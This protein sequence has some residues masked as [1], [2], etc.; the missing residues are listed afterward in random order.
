MA[1]KNKQS[2]RQSVKTLDNS[3]NLV[4]HE[5]AKAPYQIFCELFTDKL[6]VQNTKIITNKLAYFEV[7]TGKLKNVN[8]QIEQYYF[9]EDFRS[10]HYLEPTAKISIRKINLPNIEIERR[11]WQYLITEF[12]NLEPVNPNMYQAIEKAMPKKIQLEIFQNK[13][14]IKTILSLKNIQRYHYDYRLQISD[15]QI[16]Q[17]PTF[18]ELIQETHRHVKKQVRQ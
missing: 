9:F 17:V 1:K 11:A 2:F 6:S 7:I 8:N 18:A 12:L 10:V 16:H 4:V 14:T 3:D 13:L 5:L 15:S